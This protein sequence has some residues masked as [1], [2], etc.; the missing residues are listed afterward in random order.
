MERILHLILLNTINFIRSEAP[1]NVL[2]MLAAIR[3]PAVGSELLI[4][5]NCPDRGDGSIVSYLNIEFVSYVFR[6]VV[7]IIIFI[8][9]LMDN[10]RRSLAGKAL[11]SLTQV[12]A[13][14]QIVLSSTLSMGFELLTGHYSG[15]WYDTLFL[16]SAV[17]TNNCP[18]HWHTRII[19]TGTD[20]S[21]WS[22]DH[23]LEV[24]Y[25]LANNHCAFRL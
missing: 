25:C 7:R 23:L 5:L 6:I 13:D 3:L 10:R 2:V 14:Q 8:T 15:S 4:W 11:Q 21:I 1:D 22:T 18:K 20:H 17:H 16:L 19:I 12:H 9:I 24:P